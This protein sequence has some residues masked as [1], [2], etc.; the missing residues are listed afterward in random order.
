MAG[1]DQLNQINVSGGGGPGFNPQD[2]ARNA[3]AAANNNQF[4]SPALPGPAGNLAGPAGLPGGVPPG[5][6]DLTA[7]GAGGVP[8]APVAPGAAPAV[9]TPAPTIQVLF[10]KRV[11]DAVTGQLLEDARRLTVPAT[12]ADKYLDDG[13][14][15]NGIQGD[16]IRGNVETIKDQFIGNE[17]N[18]IKDQL[19][20]S[21]REAETLAPSATID[22]KD[23]SS[24]ASVGYGGAMFNKSDNVTASR[25]K[26]V[27]ENSSVM[28]FFRYHVMTVNPTDSGGRFPNLLAAEK[29]R[30]E[31]LRDWNNKF[32]ADY[33]TKKEDPQSPFFQ[34][35]VPEP[36]N[37][38]KYPV[39]PGYVAPQTIAQNGGTA[40]GQPGAP[41]RPNIY[42]GDAV[43]GAG[44]T[45]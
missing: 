10:G 19:I 24:D 17:T 44:Y 36:P 39:P 11:Y 35:Y 13:I 12:E 40:P 34:V 31:A 14:H 6:S 33:R 23:R 45:N 38:P 1:Q 26:R 43:I 9:A 27:T 21:V 41:P 2:R 16:G 3:A 32:L 37:E 30:D 15:D 5:A 28:H 29:K 7:P 22:Y 18:E 4:A 25:A 20:N 8:G 42:N